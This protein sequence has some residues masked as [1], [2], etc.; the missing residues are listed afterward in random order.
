MRSEQSQWNKRKQSKE[1]SKRAKKAKLDPDSATTAAEFRDIRKKAS[2]KEAGSDDDEWEEVENNGENDGA[3]KGEQKK[4]EE[5]RKS[6]QQPK[7]EKKKQKKP[8]P[9][10]ASSKASSGASITNTTSEK[11]ARKGKRK[12]EA[13]SAESSGN[14]GDMDQDPEMEGV[15][16]INITGFSDT[17]SVEPSGPSAILSTTIQTNEKPAKKTPDPAVR[18]EQKARLAAR[19]EAL[20][21]QRKADSLDGAPA[22]NR[23]ELMEARRKKEALRKER[24]KQMR[25]QQK[26]TEESAE[27]NTGGQQGSGLETAGAGSGS[28]LQKPARNFSFGKV[29]FDDG[30]QL[31][32][33]LQD[34]RKEKKRKGPSDILGQLK[35]TEAKKRRIE[36]MS[37][38][39]KQVVL[40]KEKW[41]KALKQATG[42]K[43]KDDEKLLKK[44]LKRQEKTKQR[45][46]REWYLIL[47]LFSL[48]LGVNKIVDNIPYR[49]ERQDG[50]A[51]AQHMKQKKREENI[52][53]RKD[54]KK[55]GKGA[56]KGPKKS[57]KGFKKMS[58]PGF[59]GGMKT[60]NG[61]LSKK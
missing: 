48:F 11:S 45:S 13:A 61:K 2:E 35:H 58:R 23:Q 29:V 39:K 43:V 51:K 40:E 41:S 34:F 24:K 20:R 55:G 26:A 10:S 30:G 8:L 37:E 46:S 49:K 50:I 52:Q 54:Q 44:A 5:G 33:S 22:K 9:A 57:V 19:I 38:E 12:L 1:E 47:M 32:H 21:A 15:A 25:L 31:D 4:K 16:P 3:R 53:A 7:K 17:T 18:A 60:V 28:A 27:S 59:E 42:E 36:N 6:K 56:K 14:S